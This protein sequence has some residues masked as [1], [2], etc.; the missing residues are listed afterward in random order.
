M[1]I[2]DR[3]RRI[4]LIIGLMASAPLCGAEEPKPYSVYVTPQLPP[5]V[6]HQACPAR[7]AIQGNRPQVQPG[8]PALDPGL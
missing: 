3:L 7:N 6:M 5:E 8:H 4:F 1:A 2:V